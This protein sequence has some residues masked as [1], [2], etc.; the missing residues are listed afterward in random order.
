MCH[1]VPIT[2]DIISPVNVSRA[3]DLH[4]VVEY[5]VDQSKYCYILILHLTVFV[6]LGLTTVT[7]VGVTFYGYFLHAC[8]LFKVAK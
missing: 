5:F 4:L 8:A 7:A 1:I 2:L 3:E 6:S